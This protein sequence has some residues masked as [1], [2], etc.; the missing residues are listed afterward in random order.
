MDPLLT[1]KIMVSK[2]LD[3]TFKEFWF[4]AR[5]QPYLSPTEIELTDC[6]MGVEVIQLFVLS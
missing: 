5:N 1:P 4:F 3:K 2:L 6:E